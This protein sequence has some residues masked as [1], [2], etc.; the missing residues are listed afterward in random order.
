MTAIP[1]VLLPHTVKL[2]PYQGRN[3]AGQPVYGATRNGVRCRIDAKRTTIRTANGSTVTGSAVVI[4]R[5]EVAAADE[6]V[7]VHGSAEYTVL[8]IEDS[9]DARRAVLTRYVVGG[10]K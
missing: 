8:G 3:A 7:F 4:T 5:P 2:K 9:T 6:S 1:N 10:P